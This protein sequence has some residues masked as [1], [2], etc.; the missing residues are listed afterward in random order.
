MVKMVIIIA[1]VLLCLGLLVARYLLKDE[2]EDDAEYF[3]FG[4]FAAGA[5]AFITLLMFKRNPSPVHSLT[6]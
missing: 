3:N 6:N 5:V 4:A 1:G 2:L